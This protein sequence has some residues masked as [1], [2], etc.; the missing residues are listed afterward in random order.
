[1]QLTK[2]TPFAIRTPPPHWGGYYWYFLRL[3]T[4]SGLVGWG[5]T[6]VLFSMYGME[7]AFEQIVEAVFNRY[8]VGRSPLN[9]EVHSKLMYAGLS[10]QHADYF[11]A[12]VISAFEVAMWDIC[13]KHFGAPVCDLLG[14]RYRERIRSYTYLY[15][16]D[17]GGD[18]AASASA[19]SSDPRRMGELAARMVDEGFTGVKLDPLRY[20]LPGA[21]PLAP[22]E[23]TME[24][25]DRAERTIEAIR[26]AVGNRADILIGT[27]GQIAPS[28]SRRLAKRL[29]KYDPLWLEEPC[30]PENFEE[31][32]LLQSTLF[33]YHVG[34]AEP[35]TGHYC[36]C[37]LASSQVAEL[38]DP[39]GKRLAPKRHSFRKSTMQ[40]R[41]S[42]RAT[43][44]SSITRRAFALNRSRTAP[45][46]GDS[47]SFAR[48]QSWRSSG[49]AASA[50][51]RP[52][53]SKPASR[54]LL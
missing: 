30:P 3:E 46:E 42:P 48:L 10:S 50:R 4:D 29:E 23:I 22:W 52:E 20:T 54:A 47:N 32:G 37:T 5:E 14:G 6:A 18:L 34:R 24:E 11:I 40:M 7:R 27:H 8:L 36:D 31:M 43:C 16:L 51:S 39:L 49:V 9:R 45:W 17:G 41:I 33:R 26:K 15:E 12:G 35:P 28:V 38:F 13:G 1:M 44:R 53:T 25:Y 19:W 2:A 21:P